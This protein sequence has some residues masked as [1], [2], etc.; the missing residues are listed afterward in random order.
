MAASM[1]EKLEKKESAA[2][3][4]P[5]AAEPISYVLITPA[6][7]EENFLGATLESIVRQT[8][9]PVRYIIVSDGSTDRTDEIVLGYAREHPWIELLRMPESKERHFGS[10]A[11]SI[12]TGYARLK[13]LEFDLVGNLDADITVEQDYYAFLTARFR[14]FPRLGV[15]GTPFVEDF[16]RP[17]RHSYAHRTANLSHVSGACQMFRRECFEEIG[18]YVPIKAGGIDWMAV[19][20]AR[21]KGWRTQTFLGKVCFHHRKMGTANSSPI[22]ARFRHGQEDYYVGGHPLWQLMR[23]IFQMKER[24]YILGGLSLLTGY[25]SAWITR[26]ECPVPE[27]V[28]LFYRK[29]QVARMKRL[30]S[31]QAREVDQGKEAPRGG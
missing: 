6:R 7:N 16:S 22:R 9:P 3:A 25:F 12:N 2:P 28:R 19:T 15:A 23:G 31:R 20:S 14:E 8:H 24:P 29:E 1:R 18:G 26:M 13:H 30:L 4:V 17:D 21:M 5:S 27:D 11:N 10:K